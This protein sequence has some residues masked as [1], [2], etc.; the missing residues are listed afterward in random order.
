[1]ARTYGRSGWLAVL[2]A[3]ATIAVAGCGGGSKSPSVASVSTMTSSS[4]ASS[5]E[6]AGATT[7]GPTSPG[8]GNAGTLAYAKCMRSNGVPN[9]PDPSPSGGFE[10]SSGIDPASPVFKTAQAK[11]QKLMPGGGFPAAGATTHPSAQALAQMVKVA[12]CMRM[13]GVSGFPDPTT[14]IP[15]GPIAGGEISDRD[16]VILVLPSSLDMQSPLFL[17]DAAAC[18]FQLSNH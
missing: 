14:S 15:S 12:R 1:M 6:V 2:A 13:H 11:C 9:F 17:R 4:T 5:T 16:G 18:G 8:D 3:A 7:S 10:F